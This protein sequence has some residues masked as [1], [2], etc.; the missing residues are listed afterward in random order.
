MH[1]AATAGDADGSVSLVEFF[2]NG[3][4]S[5]KRRDLAIRVRLGR[6]APGN[7][8]LTAVVTDNVGA[9]TAS[10]IRHITVNPSVA[11]TN[12]AL[13]SNGGTAAASSTLGP[14]YAPSAAINGDRRGQPWGAGGGWTDGTPNDFTNDLLEVTFNGLKSIDEV[15]VFSVQDNYLA[16]SS[17]R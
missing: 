12:V 17:R 16:P 2:A 9:S 5:G 1:F 4:S 13:A 11:Q 3:V 14:N 8:T 10:N 15:D 6:I 7:Y